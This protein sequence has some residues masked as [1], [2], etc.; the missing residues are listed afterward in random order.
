MV[1]APS[2]IRS[3]DLIFDLFIPA[4]LT[5]VPF[6]EFWSVMKKSSFLINLSR[7]KVVK[8]QDLVY[9]LKNNII[10]GYATDV[11]EIEKE[12]SELFNLHNTVFTPHIGAMTYEAQEE[13]G[14][15]LV[16]HI[17]NFVKS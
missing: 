10:V 8:E 7:G 9:A 12:K 3:P 17:N 6:V 4:P 13:I 5:L 16:Q 1:T 15:L 2:S 11:F 14:K